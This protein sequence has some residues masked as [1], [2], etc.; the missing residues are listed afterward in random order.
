MP[1]APA[2]LPSFPSPRAVPVLGS[3]SAVAA[4]AANGL[5]TG[6]VGSSRSPEE[7]A[8]AAD[9]ICIRLRRDIGRWI[10]SEG[11]R[12]LLERALAEAIV[13]C[14]ALEGLSCLGGE[15]QATTA[16]VRAHGAGSVA[17]GFVK[18]VSV[19]IDLLGRIIGEPMAV[20]LAERTG[21]TSPAGTP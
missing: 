8:A 10:G 1:L 20:R 19:L 9:A 16:A 3:R 7:V 6:A 11:Y 15:E 2:R 21:E 18:V 5:W 14:P 13:E 17:A 4:D 12:V